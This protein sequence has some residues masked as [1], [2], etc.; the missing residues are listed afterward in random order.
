MYVCMYVLCMYVCMHVCM[1]ECM[2]V[3]H[4]LLC[5]H[6]LL[7]FACLYKS[8][9]NQLLIFFDAFITWNSKFSFISNKLHPFN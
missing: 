2:Y 8:S 9:I 1:Y 4:Y 7:C 3:W 6:Y 5:L